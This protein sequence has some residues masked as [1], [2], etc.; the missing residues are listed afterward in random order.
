MKIIPEDLGGEMTPIKKGK[1]FIDNLGSRDLS[2]L[3]EVSRQSV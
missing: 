2:D 1:E 3:P